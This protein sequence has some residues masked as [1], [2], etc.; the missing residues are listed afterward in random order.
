MSAVGTPPNW[1]YRSCKQH[2]LPSA[3]TVGLSNSQKSGEFHV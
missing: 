1:Y 3:T 2:P